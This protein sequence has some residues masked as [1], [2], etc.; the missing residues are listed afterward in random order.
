MQWSVWEELHF[1]RD[2][3]SLIRQRDRQTGWSHLVWEVVKLNQKQFS[4]FVIVFPLLFFNEAL[5]FNGNQFCIPY[6]N[7][8]SFRMCWFLFCHSII[9]GMLM[10]RKCDANHKT[11]NMRSRSSY[12]CQTDMYT[13]QYFYRP[14]IV[15]LWLA[16]IAELTMMKMWHKSLDREHEVTI[17]WDLPDWHLHLTMYL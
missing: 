14:N 17:K 8:R 9:F 13:L 10:K 2:M 16:V 5:S 1:T 15:D 3:D 6:T 12:S 4:S 11:V 7:D